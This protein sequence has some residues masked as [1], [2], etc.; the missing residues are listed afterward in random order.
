MTPEVGKSL[1]FSIS[2]RLAGGLH[3]RSASCLAEVV[4]TFA[5][6]CVL[7]NHR[8]RA[9]AN[10]KSVLAIIAADVRQGDD[11]CVRVEGPVEESARAALR[12]FID[13]DLP[14][15]DEPPIEIDAPDTHAL[16]RELRLSGA[17]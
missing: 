12:H 15:C 8:N 7:T 13:H 1:A 17:N 11:C 3:A 2:C 14:L 9:K 10:L 4:G 5:S 16:P 6:D